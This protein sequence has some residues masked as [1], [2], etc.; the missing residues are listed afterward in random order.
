MCHYVSHL[1]LKDGLPIMG[2]TD[3]SDDDRVQNDQQQ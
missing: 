3:S 1:S 2:W